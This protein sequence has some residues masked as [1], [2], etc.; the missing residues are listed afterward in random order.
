MHL[1]IITKGKFKSR[2]VCLNVP[3]TISVT[4][5]CKLGEQ[6]GIVINIQCTIEFYLIHMCTTISF[7]IIIC[8][9]SFFVAAFSISVQMCGVAFH[10]PCTRR[11]FAVTLA[12]ST[13]VKF[14]GSFVIPPPPLQDYH[15]YTTCACIAP[16]SYVSRH[17]SCMTVNDCVQ[18]DSISMHAHALIQHTR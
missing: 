7:Y 14:Q 15:L 9:T 1:L 16:C 3:K 4:N 10:V 8:N 12:K 2:V 13:I 11:A 18:Y 5:S 17:V 6:H